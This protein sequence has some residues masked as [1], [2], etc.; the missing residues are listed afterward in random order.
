[1]R[2]VVDEL[3]GHIGECVFFSRVFGKCQLSGED[4]PLTGFCFRGTRCDFLCLVEE[5]KTGI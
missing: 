2:I 4:C 1:M 5:V 3:P